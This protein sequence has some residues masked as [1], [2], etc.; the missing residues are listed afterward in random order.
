M[1]NTDEVIRAAPVIAAARI[2][3]IRLVEMQAVTRIRT[4]KEV[5]EGAAF[6]IMQDAKVGQGVSADG[7]FGILATIGVRLQP[8]DAPPGSPLVD[9]R[10]TFE[11]RY[12]IPE[13]LQV[14]DEDLGAFGR[15][16]AVFNAWPYF[17]EFVDATMTRMHLPA[18]TLPLYR[19]PKVAPDATPQEAPSPRVKSPRARQHH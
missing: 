17:R 8:S 16:N 18:L 9:I 12:R 19:M 3:G 6:D 5:P 14:S 15:V 4:P 7:L 2:V 1:S 13:G 11:L 10:G